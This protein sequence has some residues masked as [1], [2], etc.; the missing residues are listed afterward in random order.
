MI[1]EP[2]YYCN[3]VFCQ[4]VLS[5]VAYDTK[6]LINPLLM[7]SSLQKSHIW[8][9]ISKSDVYYSDSNLPLQMKHDNTCIIVTHRSNLN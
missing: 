3:C 1:R 4:S 9:I 2:D 5:D 7:M 8:L 6:V